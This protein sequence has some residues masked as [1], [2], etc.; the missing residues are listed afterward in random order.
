MS[1]EVSVVL[2]GSQ[3]PKMRRV[4]LSLEPVEE[5]RP[6]QSRNSERLVVRSGESE[7]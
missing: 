3:E 6:E 1:A 4:F 2:E 7:G 5:R